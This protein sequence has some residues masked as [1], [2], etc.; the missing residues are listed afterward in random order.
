MRIWGS[1]VL[2][3]KLGAGIVV[4]LVAVATLVVD[5]A[6]AQAYATWN[7][8]RL[9]DGVG[10]WGGYN[11]FYYVDGSASA[12]LG[13]AVAAMDD[14]IYSTAR[15]GVSTPISFVRTTYRPNSVLDVFKTDAIT[16]WWGL[17]TLYNN[18]VEQ[19]E[20]DGNWSWAY[21][22]LDGGFA[23][24]ANQQGVIAHEMGHAMGLAHVSTPSSV[25][26]DDIAYT[27]VTAAVADDLNGINHLY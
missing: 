4:V 15:T 27:S 6:P 8:H 23:Y 5:A 22:Q 2:S 10:G 24:C 12:H 19:N 1:E 13:T 26:Y 25:M 9:W 18:D 7:D 11:Q 14:W 16:P 17:T 20:W 3:R 21:V